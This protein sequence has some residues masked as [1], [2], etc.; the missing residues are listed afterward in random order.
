MI[1]RE[2]LELTLVGDDRSCVFCSD[3]RQAGPCFGGDRCMAGSMSAPRP[4]R[5]PLLLAVVAV[6]LAAVLV[7]WSAGR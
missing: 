2:H 7:A 5:W 6:V 1:D 4:V 3:E